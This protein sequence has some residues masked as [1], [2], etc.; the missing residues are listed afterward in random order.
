[1][2]SDTDQLAVD[3]EEVKNTLELYPCIEIIQVEGD[4]PDSYE[5]EYHLKGYVRDNDG[6]VRQ[7]SQHRIRVSLPFGYPH[8]PP[9]VKPLTS[10]FHPDIDPDAVRI[11]DYW[12][13][14]PS[15]PELILHV[16]EMICCNIYNLE[17]PFNQEAADWYAEHR[18]ELPLDAIQVADITTV[19][20]SLGALED[21]TFDLLG[22]E[23]EEP[24]PAVQPRDAG[25]Q[26]DL[27]RLRIE[28]KEMFAAGKLLNEIPAST[29]VPDREEIDHVI[30]SAMRESRELLQKAE[31]L[32]DKGKLDQALE[33]VEQAADIASD[34]PGLED[35]RLRL[36]QAQV[37][38]ETF[39]G[40]SSS[41]G[42]R[43]QDGGASPPPPP[44]ETKATAAR[45]EK[46]SPPRIPLSGVPVKPILAALLVMVLVTTGGVLYFKDSNTIKQAESSWQQARQLLEKQKFQGAEEAA[47]TALDSLD[48]ILILRS[49]KKEVQDNLGKLLQSADLK[50]GLQ[51]YLKYGDQYLPA[52][53]VEKLHQLDKLTADAEKIL[54]SG[55]I[56]KAIT[57]Y[58]KAL[59]FARKHDLQPQVESLSQTINNLRFEETMVAARRAENAQEWQNAAE[60]YKRALAL[61]KN[62]SDAE[63]AEE[64]SKKLAAATFRHELDQS[65][66]SFTDA[67]WQQTIS[68]LE[69]ARKILAANPD[70]V[71]P[72]EQKEL[73]RLLADSRLYK[74]LA[75]ARAAYEK[76]EWDTAISAY[77]QA[78]DMIDKQQEIFAGAHDNA[79]PKIKKTL[80]LVEIAREQARAVAAEQ[81]NDLKT[82]L[83]HYRA[84]EQ[85]VTAPE[86]KGDADIE[87]LKKN[88]RSQIKA[89]SSQLA[90]DKKINWLKTNFE[91]IFKKAYPSSRSSEL[92]NPKVSFVKR[93]NGREI[94]RISC[95]ERNQ[96]SS[97]RLELSYQYNP[98]N[99]KWSMYSGQ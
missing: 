90:M 55:K 58:T 97:F 70:T 23:E 72:E 95:V 20:D 21:D 63:G 65:K 30:S 73:D 5:I 67:Q 85:L 7:G 78:L 91:K 3:F 60:T 48:S 41:E 87:A 98:K 74:I 69:D 8:F 66:A 26:L 24:A 51:G 33:L 57:A 76:R 37:M 75:Q 29:T 14:N 71:T 35:M 18:D 4:P 50:Q 39:S 88:T 40:I 10:I 13:K 28:Q 9:T 42:E 47:Q 64:I 53:T 45:P 79:V 84:I 59:N 1:M 94:Y 44:P 54:K 34:T 62:L 99:G 83:V 15:L 6:S 2:T 68:M 92:S 86:L 31:Q 80:L 19:D 96:G 93:E 36:Q 16:G 27:I 46:S 12:Q 11:A 43:D 38:A 32:E 89:K 49:R 17:D 22:L 25:P 77:R 61:S 81:D 56:S 52:E 82:A